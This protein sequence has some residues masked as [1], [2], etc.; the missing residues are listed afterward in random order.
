MK[1]H[2]I[3]SH[4]GVKT[5]PVVPEEVRTAIRNYME[6]KGTAKKKKQEAF[7]EQVHSGSYY[8][9]SSKASAASADKRTIRGRMNRFVACDDDENAQATSQPTQ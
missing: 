4:V 1:E 7:D 2:F 6:M 3:G 9:S 8:L 5:C